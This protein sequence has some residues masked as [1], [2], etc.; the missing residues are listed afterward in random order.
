M[1]PLLAIVDYP[2][3]REVKAIAH[4]ALGM[5]KMYYTDYFLDRPEQKI[6]ELRKALNHLEKSE[7]LFPRDWANY[8]DIGSCHMR[9]GYWGDDSSELD[10]A[11]RYLTQVVDDLRPNYGFA[12]YE[13]GRSYRI[14]GNFDQAASYFARAMAVP[15]R[16]REV[17]DY[18]VNRE[19]DLAKK[20]NSFYP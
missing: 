15:A 12:L 10:I 16:D 6:S 19:I 13:I 17:G 18:R 7:E 20:K 2:R 3:F 11:R 14:E 1:M 9:L 4:N 8:C 5:A